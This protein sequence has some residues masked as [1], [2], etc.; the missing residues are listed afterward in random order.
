MHYAAAH[1]YDPNKAQFKNFK[2][3]WEFVAGPLNSGTF[4]PNKLDNTFGPEV[5]YQSVSAE[6]KQNQAPSEG[7][8]FFG[9]VKI[10]ADSKVMTVGI[11]NLDGKKLYST[12]LQPEV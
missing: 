10:G 2:P 12:D 4:R 3:F 9:T 8:Q 6:M 7:L 1:Y 11:Y 5:K